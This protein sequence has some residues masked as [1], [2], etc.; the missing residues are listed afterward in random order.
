MV[1]STKLLVLQLQ[2]D[3]VRQLRITQHLINHD[4]PS[5]SDYIRLERIIKVFGDLLNKLFL[6]EIVM[7]HLPICKMLL[8]NK[9]TTFVLA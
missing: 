5:L 1:I 7:E 3:Q 6:L 2:H 8:T 9:G 4:Q